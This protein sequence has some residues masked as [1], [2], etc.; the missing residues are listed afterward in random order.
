LAFVN[1]LVL[2][3]AWSEHRPSAR[4]ENDFIRLHGF[5]EYGKWYFGIND[6]KPEETKDTANFPLGISKM[7]TGVAYSLQKAARANTSTITS[8]ARQRACTECWTGRKLPRRRSAHEQLPAAEPRAGPDTR[9]DDPIAVS[10]VHDP[11]DQAQYYAHEQTCHQREIERHI[12]S[13]NHNVAGQPSQPDP[14][15]IGPQQAGHH[16]C[17]AEHD[18]KARHRYQFL[19]GFFN[20][21]A[22]DRTIEAA[23]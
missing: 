11:K 3:S 19:M 6:E 1:N 22:A 15:Q 8:R 23:S 9:C 10:A 16:N 17:N 2:L 7:S 5:A 20:S 12:F 21:A 18:Q 13:L 14:A 4:E